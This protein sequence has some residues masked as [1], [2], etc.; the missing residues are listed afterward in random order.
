MFG[1]IAT[2]SPAGSIA[3]VGQRPRQRVQPVIRLR[4]WAQRSAR[5]SMNFG[6]SKV[7]TMPCARATS[8]ATATGSR[9]SARR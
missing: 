9:G 3:P 5:K 4:E 6:L 8:R 7:P 1:S 2:L